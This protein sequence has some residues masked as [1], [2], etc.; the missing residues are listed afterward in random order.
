M[1]HRD[2]CVALAAGG[3]EDIVK[4]NELSGALMMHQAVSIYPAPRAGGPDQSVLVELEIDHSTVSD[5]MCGDQ[6]ILRGV[7]SPHYRRAPPGVHTACPKIGSR[8]ESY[9]VVLNEHVGT[10][11]FGRRT[12]IVRVTVSEDLQDHEVRGSRERVVVDESVEPARARCLAKEDRDT[13]AMEIL[14]DVVIDAE[15][16]KSPVAKDPDAQAGRRVLESKARETI[17]LYVVA[18]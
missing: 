7:V 16:I 11:A 15:V 6:A 17:V 8:T 10:R 13:I 18:A 9:R 2:G 4:R 3:C 14:E 5:A 1:S 12:P